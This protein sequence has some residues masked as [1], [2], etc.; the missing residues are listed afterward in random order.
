MKIFLQNQVCY[1]SS[2]LNGIKLSKNILISL[3]LFICLNHNNLYIN[4]VVI[5]P[6]NY[7]NSKTNTSSPI[8]NSSKDY[9]E[10]FLKYNVYTTISINNKSLNFHL[11]LDRYTTYI[12]EKTLLEIDP[13]SAEIQKDE[14]LYSLAYIGIYR[15]KFANSSFT[16]LSN[17]TQNISINNYSFFMMRKLTDDLDYTRRTKYFANEGEEIGFNVLK[18]N[19]IEKVVVEEEEIDPYDKGDEDEDE[20]EQTGEKYVLQNN[21]Y[22]VE[23]KTNLITQ[24]KSQHYI[25]SYAF[26]VKYDNKSEEKGQII[27][28]GLPHQYDPRHYSE[29]YFIYHRTI[30]GNGYGNWGINFQ[31]ITYNGESFNSIKSAEFSLD[32][33]FILSTGTYKDLLDKLF[34]KKEEYAIY[35]KEEKIDSYFVKYCQEKVIKDFQ[36]ISFVLSNEYNSYNISNRLIF[37]YKDL[38]IKA[39]GDNNLYYFQIVFQEGFFKWWLGRPLFKKYPAVFDQDKHIFGFYL[40]TGEYDYNDDNNSKN[41]NETENKNQVPNEGKGGLSLA[42]IMVIILSICLVI[43]AIVIYKLLPYIKRKKKANELDEDY[44]YTTGNISMGNSNNKDLLIN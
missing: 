19:K 40:E 36:N 17:N 13:E 42:W 6:F 18:G 32:F 8:T 29:Q 12:S 23:E 37:D 25:S 1:D 26:M 34:F 14:E 20:G 35:C 27:I 24:L 4:S 41:E 22:L 38:F 3:I 7:I 15:A 31:D 43:L 44:E 33:G 16:F 11:S 5:L 30:I 2:L 28:G 39:P 10:S 9:F 21:G